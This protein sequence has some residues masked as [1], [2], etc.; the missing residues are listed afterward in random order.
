MTTSEFSNEFDVLI[1]AYANNNAI[2]DSYDKNNLAFD[3]YEKSI[4]LTKAQEEILLSYYNGTNSN[5]IGFE[6]TEEIRRYLSDLNTHVT[7][8]STETDNSIKKGS[9]I[10][11]TK[12]SDKC[13]KIP[14]NLW[15]I[16]L[17]T[18]TLQSTNECLNGKQLEVIP[19][20]QDEYNNV[21][22]NPFRGITNNRALRL[23]VEK[24][25]LE[26]ICKYDSYTYRIY[27]LS[28]P[29]P[30]ILT[31]LGDL[32]INNISTKTE[33][34]INENLHKTILNRAV[35]LAIASKIGYRTSQ[36]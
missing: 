29:T 4:F 20:T 14:E 34:S 3:E 24:G 6:A 25:Q 15:F 2:G 17:E 35:Q 16:T 31:D 26:I 13:F 33:C 22:N 23:D 27:Y 32:S 36:Q 1:N 8:D 30:I 21:I 12:I 11:N 7:I 19:I 5:Q 9:L 28:R 10:S 18:L